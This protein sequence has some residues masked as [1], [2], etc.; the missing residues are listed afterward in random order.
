MLEFLLL[1]L[2]M[3]LR[4]WYVWY[5][6]LKISWLYIMQF[7]R[8]YLSAK[9]RFIQK[10]VIYNALQINWMVLVDIRSITWQGLDFFD[11]NRLGGGGHCTP[12]RKILNIVG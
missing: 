3:E 10:L 2:N 1:T 12:L 7:I 11:I 8:K 5:M 4:A 9:T 6:K